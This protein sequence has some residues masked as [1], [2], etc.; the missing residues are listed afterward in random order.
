MAL[1]H[2]QRRPTLDDAREAAAVLE[3][4]LDPAE[5][6][7]FGSVAR[8]TQNPDSDLDLILVFD[9]LG[10]YSTR[11]DIAGQAS[12]AVRAATGLIS[13]VRVT[14][15]PEWEVRS[16]QCKSTFEAHIAS[17]A[18]TL[19]SRPP[20]SD[21]D[22]DKEIGMAPTD[23]RQ[24]AAGLENTTN[25]LNNLLHL[26]S[27]SNH[28]SDALAAGDHRYAD[29]MTHSRMLSVCAQSQTAM[30]TSF[31]ALIHALKG[32]HPEKV[33]S[34]GGLLDAARGQLEQEHADQLDAALQGVSPQAASVWRET[35][36]YPADIGIRGDP[37]TATPDFAARMAAA[38]A[39]MTRA[40]VNAMTDELGHTPP[41]ALDTLAR[42]DRITQA[43]ET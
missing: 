34:I 17:H 5:V 19:R 8:G 21:I 33:H 1:L 14:D 11:R 3:K 31:K 41:A 26:L 25:A 28:E 36:T 9:D 2:S 40:C 15:R 6:L 22:W 42:C 38:A 12:D 39:A 4:A 16:K 7:L 32:P 37:A 30:E 18:V 43:I 13:D 20:N 29:S 23:E 10:D 24:A 27:P 35:G